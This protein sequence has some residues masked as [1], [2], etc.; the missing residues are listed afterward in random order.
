MKK[1]LRI[2]VAVICMVAIV[3]GYYYYLSHKNASVNAEEGVNLTEVESIL[4]KDFTDDYPVTP[5]S[6]V[7]WYNRIITAYYAEDYSDEEFMELADQA[8]M[9]LDEELLSYNPR[10]NYLLSLIAEIEDYNNRNKVI[11]SSSVCDTSEVEYATVNGYECAYVSAYYFV[12]EGSTYTRTY[13]DYC[14]RK[15][16]DGKW[17]ILTWQLSEKDDSD[18]F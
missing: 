3:V 5:R 17:K 1:V 18:E 2:S 14:L 12:R 4:A 8:R 16:S 7:K 9:L 11:V 13:E 6:V 15:D 10:E